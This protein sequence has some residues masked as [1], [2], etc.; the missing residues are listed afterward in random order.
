[1]RRGQAAGVCK[2]KLPAA[3]EARASVGL[4]QQEFASLPGVSART[5]QGWEQGR[6]EPAGGACTLLKIA[7]TRQASKAF[8][9]AGSLT[10]DPSTERTSRGLGYLATDMV[11]GIRQDMLDKIVA[12]IP[13]KRLGTPDDSAS[14]VT[15]LA[16]EESVFATGAEFSVTAAR[17]IRGGRFR[18]HPVSSVDDRPMAGYSGSCGTGCPGRTCA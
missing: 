5:L 8:A 9:G 15:W 1:M 3:A 11:K 18:R 17:S 6:R 14:M 13:G 16:S 10:L 12:G 7:V 4:S 2:V